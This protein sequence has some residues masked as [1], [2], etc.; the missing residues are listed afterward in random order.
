[1]SE[2]DKKPR[3]LAVD[4]SPDSGELI[5]RIAAGCGYEAELVCDSQLAVDL[6]RAWKPEVITLDLGMPVVDG[7]DILLRLHDI[8]FAGGVIIISGQ[9]RQQREYAVNIA[10]TRGL[11]VLDHLAKPVALH[12]LRGLLTMAQEKKP[13]GSTIRRF[14]G[15]S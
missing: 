14:F 5:V 1:M 3:L 7:V 9:G 10:R 8:G 4:D 6:A 15:G 13:A 12:A 11:K 2:T